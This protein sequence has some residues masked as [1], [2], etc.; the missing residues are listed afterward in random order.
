MFG[1]SVVKM[2]YNTQEGDLP[3]KRL[4]SFVFLGMALTLVP[5]PIMRDIP[6]GDPCHPASQNDYIDYDGHWHCE[7]Q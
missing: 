7:L 3:V 1:N 5:K 2:E 6:P 4:F